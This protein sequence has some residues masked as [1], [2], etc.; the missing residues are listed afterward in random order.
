VTQG[1]WIAPASPGRSGTH[2]SGS[3]QHGRTGYVGMDDREAANARTFAGP[4]R[5]VHPL[6]GT[7]SQDHFHRFGDRCSAA[8]GMTGCHPSI[9][10]IRSST[11][12]ASLS[13]PLAM[14]RRRPRM[15]S[16]S[17]EMARA[18]THASVLANIGKSLPWQGVSRI[19]AQL[20]PPPLKPSLQFSQNMR[21]GS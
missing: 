10:A 9:S 16:F 12:Y 1:P 14:L 5:G 20:Q 2:P 13:M 3:S 4:R 15:H 7:S 6:N 18:G 17:G 11:T 21:S 19:A 8:S